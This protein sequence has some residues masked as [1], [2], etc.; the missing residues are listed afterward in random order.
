MV[1]IVF[2]YVF[3]MFFVTLFNRAYYCRHTSFYESFTDNIEGT[4]T[5]RAA[6]T[7]TTAVK[8][9]CVLYQTTAVYDF[10]YTVAV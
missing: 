5:P 8:L 7:T 9:L 6:A 1:G 3:S 4:A 10:N 2:F